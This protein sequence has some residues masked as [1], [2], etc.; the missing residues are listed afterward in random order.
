[1]LQGASEL[2]VGI[3]LLTFPSVAPETEVYADASGNGVHPA[4]STLFT[5]K[6]IL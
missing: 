5:R 1:M 2:N 6:Q 4:V 3:K